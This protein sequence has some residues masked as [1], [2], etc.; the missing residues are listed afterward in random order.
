MQT[1]LTLLSINIWSQH[2]SLSNAHDLLTILQ[3]FISTCHWRAS[4]TQLKCCECAHV[5]AEEEQLPRW[6]KKGHSTNAD[7]SPHR[8]R[9][10]PTLDAPK[11]NLKRK[12]IPPKKIYKKIFVRSAALCDPFF[13]TCMSLLPCV[14]LHT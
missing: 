10:E 3:L 1:H 12:E 13:A 2:F 11:K 9:W 14:F 7:G 6:S 5:Q 4:K 8:Y